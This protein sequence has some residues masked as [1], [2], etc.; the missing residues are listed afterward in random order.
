MANTVTPATE[1]E[2]ATLTRK[3]LASLLGVSVSTLDALRHEGQVPQP[4]IAC[5]RVLRWSRSVVN[6]WIAA[7]RPEQGKGRR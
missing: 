4:H 2:S 3:Q 5:G 1:A 6:A 7:N